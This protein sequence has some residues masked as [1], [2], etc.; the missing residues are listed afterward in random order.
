M[1]EGGIINSWP[2]SAG[3]PLW[4]FKVSIYMRRIVDFSTYMKYTEYY[5][6]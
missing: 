3:G 6:S 5:S 1:C 4:A 2:S